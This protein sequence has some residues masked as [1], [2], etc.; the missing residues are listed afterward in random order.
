MK[1]AAPEAILRAIATSADGRDVT[2]GYLDAMAVIPSQDAIL[3]D[4]GLTLESYEEILR[5]D[6][7]AATFQQRRMAVTSAEW[8]VRSG[9]EDRAS[10]KAADFLKET[11]RRIG[12]DN[13]TD[14]MLFGVFFGYAVAECLWARDGQ[15]IV[16]DALK[17]RKQ[18]RFAFGLDSQ[19]RLLTASNPQGEALPER[20]FWYFS[21]GAD[22]DDEPYGLGLAHWLYWPVFFKRN[23][24]KLWMIF[25]DKFGMPTA[26]G[27]FPPTASQDE[28]RR[29]LLALEAI[30][31]DS[32]IIIPDG[33][34]VSLI[35]ASRS[36]SPSYAE[37]LIHMNAAIAKVVLSQTLTTESVGGQYKAEVQKSVRNEVV[38]ADS[39]LVCDA[40]NR[41]V[42]RWLTEWNFPSAASPRVVRVTQE[43][44]DLTVR[45]AR[46]KTLVDMG[47]RPTL[48][49]IR[50]TYG[51]GWKETPIQPSAPAR[52]AFAEF[53][54]A[55]EDDGPADQYTR[56]AMEKAGPALAGLMGPIRIALAEAES[57]I[58]FRDDLYN[59]YPELD[60]ISLA[61]LLAGAM[62][63][64]DL[65]G[66]HE[67]HQEAGDA[68]FAEEIQYGGLPFADAIRFFR[69]K[70]NVPTERWDDLSREQHDIG[71]MVAGA[72]KAD[73]LT[74]LRSAIDRSI[75][76]GA[77]LEAFRRDFDAIVKKRGWAYQGGRGW[78]TR[79][80]LETN[81][82][83]SYQAGRY[84]QMTDPDILKARP[85]W[86]YKH[87]GSP[88]PRQEHL[89]WSGMV[90][91]ADDPWWDAHY[92]SNGWGCKCRAF[93]LSRR[94]LDRMGKRGPDPTPS[95]GL[96]GI[97]P[98]WDYTPG[99]HSP[100][101]NTARHTADKL[102]TMPPALG[103]AFM[104][105]L[106]NY[107]VIPL[108][109]FFSDIPNTNGDAIS[110]GELLRWNAQAGCPAYKTFKGK[111]TYVEHDN[112][113]LSKAKGVILDVFISPLKGF[114]GN[115]AK[116]V[117]LAAFDRTKDEELV[118]RIS[119][120]EVNTYSI[121]AHYDEYVCSAS[122][123]RYRQGQPN[124]R[125]T[126]PG[127][128]TYIDAN[129]NLIYR[130]LCQ[131]DGFELSSVS[132]P[133]F[134][135]ALSDDIISL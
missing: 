89:A 35:E 118:R 98:G 71:F 42:A 50:E 99:K 78:R 43:P 44:D 63:A 13:A 47:F 66:R 88:S 3:R 124:G 117:M 92:P 57:L 74:D 104:E 65:A 102:S 69:G 7:V 56:Q 12:W 81:I 36:G 93:T 29:L 38:Q 87:S 121:G 107:V 34:D 23:G 48:D 41:T 28:Q 31:T 9:A 39:D 133:A 82:W 14:K 70:V 55:P 61:R 79:V 25:L 52:A 127:I 75:S 24:V 85:Y 114:Q 59:L 8:E 80:I 111:P 11:L 49:Y 135:T 119:N 32:A 100:A 20:K 110:K 97:D 108:V 4:Q 51:P 96:E 62:L 68:D 130:Y 72:A 109:S 113:D 131:I 83:S 15:H 45:S 22:N 60:A 105:D 106:K 5:D 112:K 91:R 46:D 129:G 116:V 17:V 6:Q 86:Q 53:D 67:V 33:M 19:P 54:P 2:R 123:L 40:F 128:P 37:M 122:G 115:H 76:E 21:T 90:L 132:Y 84:R 125:Y 18:R 94:D 134:T 1:N 16:L 27:V 10:R 58:A 26:K 95:I 64:A 126:K 30:Q 101:W 120:R 73:L 103:A 77:T